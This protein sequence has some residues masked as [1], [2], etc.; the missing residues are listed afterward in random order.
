VLLLPLLVHVVARAL[1]LAIFY[2]AD[3]K[4][5]VFWGSLAQLVGG[6]PLY[7]EAWRHLSRGGYAVPFW[8]ALLSSL[9]Y[10]VSLYAALVQPGTG[11]LFLDRRS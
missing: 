4:L 11:V 8:F 3:P 6:L 5:Q 7:R 1:G 9:V 10:G 2:V